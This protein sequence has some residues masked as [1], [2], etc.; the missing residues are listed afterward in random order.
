MP[1]GR[2]GATAPATS[3]TGPRDVPGICGPSVAHHVASASGPATATCWPVLT[4]SQVLLMSHRSAARASRALAD[5]TPATAAA[6]IR[7]LAQ[8]RQPGH[9]PA[10]GPR[11]LSEVTML[12]ARPY[13]GVPRLRASP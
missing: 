7:R 4:T 8:D 5:P 13:P 11:A 1:S 6:A 12:R 9:Q 3:A 2:T 10:P